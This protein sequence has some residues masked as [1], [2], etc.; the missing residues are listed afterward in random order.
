MDVKEITVKLL[1][2]RR[3]YAYE[4]GAP[5]REMTGRNEFLKFRNIEELKELVNALGSNWFSGDNVEFYNS[6]VYSDLYGGRFFVSSELTFD[7]L[8]C[9]SV[10]ECQNGAI[11]TVGEFNQYATLKQAKRAAIRAAKNA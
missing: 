7:G 6:R 8:R 4:L 11:E 3:A 10:R 9:Y 5:L 1:N 2:D